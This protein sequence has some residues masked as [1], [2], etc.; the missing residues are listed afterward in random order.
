[1]GC[2]AAIPG[3]AVASDYVIAQPT[4]CA[5]LHGVAVTASA[6]PHDTQARRAHAL[7]VDAGAALVLAPSQLEGEGLDVVAVKTLTDVGSTTDITWDIT[8]RFVLG[9]LALVHVV[10]RLLNPGC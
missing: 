4:S 10:D 9:F 6:V 1:M 2:Y 5:D 7:F 3:L 8:N